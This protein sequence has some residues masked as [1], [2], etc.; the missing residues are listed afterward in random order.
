DPV[1][2]AVRGLVQ[3]IGCKIVQREHGGVAAGK[4]VFNG[5]Q[6]APVAEGALCEKPDFR[7]TV[8]ND[9]IG[10]DTFNRVEYRLDRLAQLKVRRIEKALL[11]ILVEQVFGWL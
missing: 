9:P 4:V 10:L 1:G 2:D 6:L 11:L 7:Q 3:N 5:E 8:E